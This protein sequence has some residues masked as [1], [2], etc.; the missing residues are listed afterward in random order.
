MKKFKYE[1]YDYDTILY[2][3]FNKICIPKDY[4]IKN[5][6]YKD[7]VIYMNVFAPNEDITI[8]FNINDLISDET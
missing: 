3:G 8:Q 6:E 1:K 2:H 4:L 5:I 7:G